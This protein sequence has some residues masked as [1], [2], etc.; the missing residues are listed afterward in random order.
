MCFEELLCHTLLQ[1]C[2][3]QVRIFNLSHSLDQ[4]KN[5]FTSL[6]EALHYGNE[7]LNIS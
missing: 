2:H 5:V 1:H 7:R 4:E 6:H 3:I